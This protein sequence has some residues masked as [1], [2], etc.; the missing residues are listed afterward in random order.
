M[1]DGD[2]LLLCH[3]CGRVV[4]RS[5]DSYVL[6]FRLDSLGTYFASQGRFE[7]KPWLQHE[8][9][10]LTMFSP[11]IVAGKQDPKNEGDDPA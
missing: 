10:R 11:T 1:Q 9:A 8:M 3:D 7:P 5:F 4:R 2:Q 6:H